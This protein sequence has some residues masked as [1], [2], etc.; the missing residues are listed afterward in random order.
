MTNHSPGLGN[1]LR[2]QF[3]KTGGWFGNAL[4]I[5]IDFFFSKES[6]IS[7]KKKNLIYS[8]SIKI[9]QTICLL[10]I[11]PCKVLFDTLIPIAS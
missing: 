10:Q 9:V 6:L 8:V 5:K 2:Y 11:S 3:L 1:S 7:K 4:F